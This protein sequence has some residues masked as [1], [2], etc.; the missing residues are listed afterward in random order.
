MSYRKQAEY[1]DHLTYA[2]EVRPGRK[3]FV[4]GGAAGGG[5]IDSI[6]R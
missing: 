4:S 3:S 2:V 1:E 5:I 6:D